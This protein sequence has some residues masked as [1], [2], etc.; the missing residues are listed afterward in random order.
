MWPEA[1]SVNHT[2]FIYLPAASPPAKAIWCIETFYMSLRRSRRPWPGQK[3]GQC[4]CVKEHLCVK[5]AVCKGF[6][7]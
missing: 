1:N 4:V 5:A 6:C 2:Y 3:Q 7:V